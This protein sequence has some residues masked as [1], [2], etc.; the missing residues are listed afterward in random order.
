MTENKTAPYN[1]AEIEARWQKKWE[2]DGLYHSDVDP[3]RQ[4]FYALTML[5]YPSGDLHI[6]HWYAM[7]PS[8]ARA[9]FKRMNGFNVMFPIGFD[10][11]GLPA[12]NAAINHNIHPKEWTYKNIER[13]RKQLKSMGAMFDW[14][15]EAISADPEYYRWTQW[16][17]T[18]LYKHGLAYQKK[19]PVDWC[20]HCNTTLAREQV[21]GDDRHCERCGTPVI[22]KNLKQWYFRITNYADEL[23]D[24]SK[25]DWPER[26]QTLEKNWIGER[27]DGAA[28]FFDTE[29]GDKLEV[30]TTRPDT[31]WGV[32]F[33]VLAPEHFLV[34]KITSP[35]Q[36][37]AVEAYVRETARQSDIQREVTDRE[38]TGVFTGGYAINPVSKERV[39]IWI[40]DYVLMS[41][42]TG[43]IMAVPAHDERD[44]AF[45]YKFHLPIKVVIQAPGEAPADPATMTESAVAHGDMINSG[46]L[47]G[48][49]GDKAFDKAIE[50]VES[51]GA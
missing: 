3:K 28:V 24:F 44:F 26:V 5:P 11:F 23:K 4:K 49:P 34:E 17:F 9:R 35:E 29:V 2:A 16:F 38:K 27:S 13:M 14:R 12:E 37:A 45:A 20:P 15:R 40:A 50:Y 22:R 30:F 31:L 39:P 46:I 32:T 6:G 10:A 33:M 48:T 18:Q 8:D 43:A 42:G 25:F 1:P 21:W 19:S 47:S 41:Y 7:V 51:L 36:K